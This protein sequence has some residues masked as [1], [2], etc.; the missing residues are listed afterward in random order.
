MFKWILRYAFRS[1][2]YVYEDVLFEVTALLKRPHNPETVKE[3]K[4]LAQYMKL[5]RP[6]IAQEVYKF[7]QDLIWTIS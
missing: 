1:Q 6:E 3:M 4:A 7:L 2:D 5:F